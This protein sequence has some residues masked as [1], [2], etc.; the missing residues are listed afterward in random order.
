MTEKRSK[1]KGFVVKI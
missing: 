1:R